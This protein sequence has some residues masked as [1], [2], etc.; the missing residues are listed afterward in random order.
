MYQLR[1]RIWRR[2][3]GWSWFSYIWRWYIN[4]VRGLPRWF[5]VHNTF[6]T[7]A[8]SLLVTGIVAFVVELGKTQGILASL[9]A[10]YASALFFGRLF[11]NPLPT[12]SGRGWSTVDSESHGLVNSA[13]GVTGGILVQDGDHEVSFELEDESA[14]TDTSVLEY[15]FDLYDIGSSDPHHVIRY[16]LLNADGECVYASRESPM[17]VARPHELIKNPD[18]QSARDPL[19][20]VVCESTDGIDGPDPLLYLHLKISALGSSSLLA[21]N[22]LV[23]LSPEELES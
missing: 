11:E 10:L 7:F 19:S 23:E 1:S 2:C 14:Y 6:S 12:L 8:F 3:M 4:Y 15:K 5:A 22:R 18:E 17:Q 20:I 9:T 13:S 16:Q 21:Y